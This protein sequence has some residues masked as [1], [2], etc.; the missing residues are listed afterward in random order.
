MYDE[1][2]DTLSQSHITD[3]T[4][5]SS[6]NMT[7]MLLCHGITLRVIKL[8]PT[9]AALIPASSSLPSDPSEYKSNL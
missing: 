3:H 7:S 9:A 5:G 1:N 8:P 6:D 4:S 2:K